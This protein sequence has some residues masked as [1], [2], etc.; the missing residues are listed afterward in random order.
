MTVFCFG[1]CRSA[2]AS[3]T[4]RETDGLE[5]RRPQEHDQSNWAASSRRRE[6]QG[7]TA[8]MW[9]TEGPL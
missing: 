4:E 9:F 1:A 6:F 3:A 7:V 2:S 8:M 5:A